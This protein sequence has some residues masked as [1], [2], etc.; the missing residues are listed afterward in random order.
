MSRGHHHH[1][2]FGAQSA[3]FSA[4]GVVGDFSYGVNGLGLVP[5]LLDELN[6]Y[7]EAARPATV[8]EIDGLHIA[9]NQ[10][11][12]QPTHRNNQDFWD[13]YSLAPPQASGNVS[14]PLIVPVSA[15]DNSPYRQGEQNQRNLI[16]EGLASYSSQ[17][18]ESYNM[19]RTV[20]G[21]GLRSND[22]SVTTVEDTSAQAGQGR[23]NGTAHTTAETVV[24]PPAV[25]PRLHRSGRGK[26]QHEC[27]DCEHDDALEK[28]VLG[29]VNPLAAYRRLADHPNRKPVCSKELDRLFFPADQ[30]HA[31]DHEY[32]Y[33]CQVKMKIN[34]TGDRWVMLDTP[35]PC[36]ETLGTTDCYRRHII[37]VHLNLGRRKSHAKLREVLVQRIAG[38]VGEGPEESR[39][40]LMTP[41][42]DHGQ[43]NQ[44]NT[45]RNRARKRRVNVHNADEP[46]ETKRR[47]MIR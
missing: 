6:G 28:D 22:I 9:S 25:S 46:R 2:D 40:L 45:N 36:G 15:A 30:K 31:H 43:V 32:R 34:D 38:I 47:H 5:G 44:G 20:I 26:Y 21:P 37:G 10:D 7:L 35:G 13:V 41:S 29:Y 27:K 14:R 18:S 3:T 12:T 39:D 16:E 11:S 19:T 8:A 24:S 42:V 17:Y 23:A 4:T 33:V 1:L